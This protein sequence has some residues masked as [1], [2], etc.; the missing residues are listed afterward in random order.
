MRNSAWLAAVL[1]AACGGS[2]S[3]GGRDVPS[4]AD[5]GIVIPGVDVAYG[6]GAP[7]DGGAD[8]AADG[9]DAVTDA[10]ADG[11]EEPPGFDY[12]CT[13]MAFEACV[14]AC[15]SAGQRKC[16]KEWGPCFPPQEFCG[17]CAD[18]DC[19]GLINEGCVPNPK[20][21][22]PKIECPV[23][24][25]TVSEGN[26]AWTKDTLHMTAAGSYAQ[27]GGKVVKWAW[28][29]KAPAGASGKLLPSAD[30]ETVT[31]GPLDAAG[32]YLFELD[33]WDDKGTKSCVPAVASVNVKTWPPLEPE[34]GC[35]DGQREGFLDSKAWP[36]IAACAGAWDKPGITPDGVVPTCGL[37]GG[38]DGANPGGAGCSAPDLCAAGWHV[39]KGW[40]DVAS[41]SDTGCAG[42][43]PPDAK[44]KSLFFAIRQP[45]EN[46]SVCGDWGDGFNDVFGCGNLGAG[47]GP[48]KGCGPLDRVLASTQPN[49]C[50][51]N[52]AMPNLGPWECLGTG[53]SDLNEGANVT[54][55]ACQ[56]ASCSY[57]G[58]PVGSSDKGGVLCCRD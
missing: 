29:A 11:G 20:C 47:L 22:P 21:E 8:G 30:V 31:F 49:S 23:A 15:G 35:A 14:T 12:P 51:F 58:Y 25:I 55:K 57:D 10:K 44:Q 52:E 27:G 24:I 40:Q 3:T 50:G 17:N 13:P 54:K 6:D 53:A 48:D 41:R 34:V 56:N 2:A 18:D 4:E 32:S 38:D 45:S 26:E 9:A 5:A 46:H 39:C 7:G 37:A 42:A 36:Q 19:D 43:T 16:L 28:T 33:V 1:L